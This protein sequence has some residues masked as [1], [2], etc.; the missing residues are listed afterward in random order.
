MK[1]LNKT[2][3]SLIEETRNLKEA[4]CGVIEKNNAMSKIFKVS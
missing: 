4:V 2:I 3:K 1:E